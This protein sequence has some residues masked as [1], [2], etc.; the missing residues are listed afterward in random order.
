MK[1]THASVP[2]ISRKKIPFK[3][4][5]PETL[6]RSRR[7]VRVRP[8][9]VT[10]LDEVRLECETPDFIDPHFKSEIDYAGFKSLEAFNNR[11]YRNPFDEEDP[12][13]ELDFG[14]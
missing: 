2:S 14:H 3:A 4:P 9:E 8:L 11:E 13:K 7:P 10:A 1:P 5:V 12:E 6:I